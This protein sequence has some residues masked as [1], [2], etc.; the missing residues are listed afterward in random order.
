VV[1][2]PC[3]WPGA[4]GNS[5]ARRYAAAAGTENLFG[6]KIRYTRLTV[7][8]ISSTRRKDARMRV[9]AAASTALRSA[10]AGPPQRAD[11]LGTAPSA[12]Y[13]QIVGRPGVLAILAH[14][15]V[16]LPCG[17]LLPHTSGELPL[18]G[19]A[20]AD[21]SSTPCLVGNGT[22]NW[23][24]LAGPIVISPVRQWAPARV[25]TGAVDPAAVARTSAAVPDAAS[26]GVDSTGLNA[27]PGA[28]PVSAVPRLL[29][30]GPGLTPSGDDVLAGFLIGAH[31]FGLDVTALRREVRQRAPDATTALSATLLWHAARGECID[32]VAGLA[33]ALCGRGA[34]ESALSR[35]LAVGHTSGAALAWGL[36]VAAQQARRRRQSGRCSSCP[37]S[38]DGRNAHG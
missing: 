3:R 30:Q 36:T 13:L 10:L 21:P 28:Q 2:L 9:A 32:E 5:I 22:V 29:G 33:A 34:P 24:G 11:W 14:D 19:L 15:A 17:L 37:A 4:A 7:A 8:E 12:L 20:P 23:T 31:A 35:L 1:A 18:T 25:S 16:R 6:H 27:L 26:A 38:V